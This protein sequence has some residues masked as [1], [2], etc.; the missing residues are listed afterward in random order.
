VYGLEVIAGRLSSAAL[1]LSGLAAVLGP[2][3][4]AQALHLP[5]SSGRGKAE[6]R[7]ALGGTY[8]ALGAWALL[9]AE[10]AARTAVGVTWLGA[11]GARLT[12]LAFDKPETDSTYWSYLALEVGAGLAA[13]ASG[14]P[15]PVGPRT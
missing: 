12:A 5:A 14:R 10:P 9:S 6:V 3:Q 8:L 4:V 7:A 15:R 11:A 13:V 1:M 2:D